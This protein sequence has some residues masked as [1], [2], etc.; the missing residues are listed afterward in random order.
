MLIIELL[1]HIHTP[2]VFQLPEEL[3]QHSKINR[4]VGF[5]LALLKDIFMRNLMAFM[6][7]HCTKTGWMP[8]VPAHSHPKDDITSR[9]DSFAAHHPLQQYY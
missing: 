5:Q 6:Q 3:A 4:A 8:R 7:P 9:A 2:G 1:L